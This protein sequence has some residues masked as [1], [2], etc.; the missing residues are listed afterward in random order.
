MKQIQVKY[1]TG[2][3]DP[4]R[5]IAYEMRMY[6]CKEPLMKLS[7]IDLEEAKAMIKDALNGAL[8]GCLEKV[9]F[10][11]IL[12]NVPRTFTHQ[13]VRTRVGAS[14][15]QQSQRFTK[16]D[17]KQFH[18]P[19]FYP[20]KTLEKYQEAC[21]KAGEAYD[22]L[23]KMGMHP[24]DARNVLP[25]ATNTHVMVSWTLKTL[26]DVASKR[27][28]YQAQPFWKVVFNQIRK[29]I[30]LNVDPFFAQLMV[31]PCASKGFCPYK[32]AL[33]RDCP[34]ATALGDLQKGKPKYI[35]ADVEPENMK[36]IEKDLQQEI[37]AIGKANQKQHG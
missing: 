15:A 34:V 18:T 25:G 6:D 12:K 32:S 19:T 5:T 37:I 2:T 10:V 8:W 21:L 20:Q 23:M 1:L 11:F 29:E 24:Q 30:A 27:T 13:L 22:E 3:A 35:H 4:I 9:A 16:F 7:D 17:E 28:C 14:Y 36:D 31:P 33:D 26:V